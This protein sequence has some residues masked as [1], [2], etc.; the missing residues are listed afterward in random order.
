MDR[1]PPATAWHG[2]FDRPPSGRTRRGER[3]SAAWLPPD[4]VSEDHAAGPASSLANL[5]AYLEDGARGS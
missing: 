5:A 1:R 4:F 2:S 3:S